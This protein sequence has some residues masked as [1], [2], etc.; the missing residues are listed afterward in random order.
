MYFGQLLSGL[1]LIGGFFKNFL[2]NLKF[3]HIQFNFAVW[4][5]Q[6]SARETVR[7]E[8]MASV[9]RPELDI[10]VQNIDNASLQR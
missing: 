6:I 5:Q 3:L 9:S 1:S 10:A 2:E 4:I 7:K 8:A